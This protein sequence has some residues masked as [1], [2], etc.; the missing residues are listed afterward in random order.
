[1]GDAKD[2]VSRATKPVGISR[3]PVGKTG[4]EISVLGFGGLQVGDYWKV[5]PEA[6]AYATIERALAL[7]INYFDTAPHY[8]TGLSEHRLGHVLR[9]LSR[10]TF[11]LSTK[12]ARYLVPA[13]AEKLADPERRGLPFMGVY[14]LSYDATMRAFDQSLQRLGL[15]QIDFL[16]IHDLDPYQHGDYY[17]QRFKE[18]MAGCYPA[19]VRLRE[20]KVVRGI[21]GGI[22]THQASVRLIQE[23]DLDCV[24]VAGRYTLLE[25][26]PARDLLPLAARKGT[27]LVLGAPFNTGI[28]ATGVVPGALY[29]NRPPPPD[30]VDRVSR[31]DV[32]C[33]R[34]GIAIA[35]AALQFPLGHASVA[36][37]VPG[38]GGITDVERNLAL[39]Q[40]AI[41]DAF[42]AEL[43]REGL[44]EDE[45][46]TPPTAL[47]IQR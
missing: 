40:V 43:R 41:P 44:L 3:R 37:V 42:W 18:A 7:G 20:Q 11:V 14:D 46:P 2:G 33:A 29:N 15:E 17:D 24:M 5:M 21:G 13:D 39:M 9:K 19:L 45:V 36:S 34:H 38:M 26:T 28:L 12:V 47:A 6:E 25:Q 30:I 1:M 10:H 31:M 35:A 16:F 8:G 27:S 23:M 4:L 22:N 32:V